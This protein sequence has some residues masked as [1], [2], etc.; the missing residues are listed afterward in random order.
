MLLLLH[1][2]VGTQRLQGG[3][4]EWQFVGWPACRSP[5]SQ[6]PLAKPLAL[7]RLAVR[8]SNIFLQQ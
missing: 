2:H 4:V 7:H 3:F 5:V 8:R 6:R 1:G